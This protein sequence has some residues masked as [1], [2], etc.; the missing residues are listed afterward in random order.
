MND[1]DEQIARFLAKRAGKASGATAPAPAKTATT[2]PATASRPAIKRCSAPGTLTLPKSLERLVSVISGVLQLDVR[3]E[4]S[5]TA[6]TATYTA[7]KT[8]APAQGI[9]ACVQAM[10]A[11]HPM[12]QG[13]NVEEMCARA[14]ALVAV[15]EGRGAQ[16]RRQEL[17]EINAIINDAATITGGVAGSSPSLAD[18]A[19][20]AA[21]CTIMSQVTYAD[22]QACHDLIR[23]LDAVQH[24]PGIN[25]AARR[26]V[27]LNPAVHI[28]HQITAANA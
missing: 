5:E 18:F 7:G 15:Q 14:E 9:F 12:L 20:W 28:A 8:D 25:P 26:N 17:A 6:T 4:V 3:T 24:T 21:V 19:M 11:Q 16:I 22:Y 2:T 13:G 27:V 10:C 23:W 1:A